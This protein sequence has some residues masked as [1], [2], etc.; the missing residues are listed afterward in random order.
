[1]TDSA[2]RELA[3]RIYGWLAASMDG[4]RTLR[5]QWD[6]DLRFWAGDPSAHWEGRRDRWISRDIENYTYSLVEQQSA[7]LTD[8]R[9]SVDI[10]PRGD[11]GDEGVA[12]ILSQVHRFIWDD[13]G[14]STVLD[15]CAQDMVRLGL[16]VEKNTFDPAAEGGRGDLAVERVSPFDL[17][18]DPGATTLRP[19]DGEYIIEVRRMSLRRIR[20]LFPEAGHL[21][22]PEDDL[23][24]AIRRASAP[25][26]LRFDGP[27]SAD[28]PSSA[29]GEPTEALEG[30]DARPEDR[31]F[32]IEC[33]YSDEATVLLDE[34]VLDPD[35]GRPLTELDE[36]GAV[37]TDEAGE[38]VVLM[39][40]VRR[41]LY[42]SGRCTVVAA[43]VVLLDMPN[44]Y[45]GFPYSFYVN[46]ERDGVLLPFGEIR[47][48]KPIQRRINKRQAQV[49]HNAALMANPQ[50]LVPE[51][52]I[53]KG[54]RIR[55][56]PGAN[57]PHKPGLPPSQTQPASLPDYV[58]RDLEESRRS[59]ERISG[60]TP[61]ASGQGESQV[62]AYRAIVALQDSAMARVRKLARR[63]DEAVR[64]ATY[65]RLFIIQRFVTEERVFRI[66]G[67]EGQPSELRINRF[68]AAMGR[69]VGD[70]TAGRY[71]VALQPGSTMRNP[72]EWD[73]KRSVEMLRAGMP[74]DMET[75][76][77]LCGIDNPSAVIAKWRRE[78]DAP[79][80]LTEGRS[81]A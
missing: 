49:G 16:G 38:P 70:V 31:A 44:P 50:W 26:D 29:W 73:F 60:M 64:E 78:K 7:L 12:R 46:H 19:Y 17:F 40:K 67:P 1:M 18:F 6:E 14:L 45:R 74:L 57:I 41:P 2:G 69:V 21:V 76:M 30:E 77:S 68:D 39:R 58:L 48:I 13:K 27:V 11:E 51:G 79:T 23:H 43:G 42:P 15:R 81:D 20:A 8:A 24:A 36:D 47:Q 25:A 62:S 4:H 52:S 33:W 72:R 75:A 10:V 34:P 28:E 5:E 65:Q 63:V 66:V 22:E 80:E 56:E 9:P 59:V 53:K 35:T 37:V 55:N 3:G 32:V 54:E 71:D 61:V